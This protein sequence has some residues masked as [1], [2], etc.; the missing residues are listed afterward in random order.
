MTIRVEGNSLFAP[1]QLSTVLDLRMQQAK[2]AVSKVDPNELLSRPSDKIEYKIFEEYQMPIVY[3]DQSKMTAPQVEESSV[4][5][6]GEFSRGV[7]NDISTYVTA[8][9]ISLRIPYSGGS[10]LFWLT[11]STY[12]LNPPRGYVH[13]DSV[14]VS[15]LVPTDV[16][17]REQDRAITELRRMIDSIEEWINWVNRDIDEWTTQLRAVIDT[18]I[19][20]RRKILLEMRKI[21]TK[22]EVPIERDG[23]VARTYS[24]PVLKRRRPIQPTPRRTYEPFEPE[25]GISESNF[26]DIVTDITSV[27]TMFERLPITHFEAKEE[28]LR[29]QI[30]VTLNAI[31]GAGSA[32]TFSKR[33]KTDIY[34]P[35]KDNA[36][37]IAECK[38]WTG[39][40]AFSEE[41]LPQLLDQYVIWRDTHTAMILFI[42]NK[43][44][45]SVIEQAVKSVQQYPRYVEDTSPIGEM[46]TF[47]LHKEGDEDR[48]L[49]L[50]LITASI[51]SD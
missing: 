46:Q 22:L 48:R 39:Q 45:S 25:P 51:H 5:V 17:S 16:L 28:R 6:R 49:K 29:D 13:E 9:R 23:A 42:K 7:S 37:F 32:E 2:E 12:N 4:D 3:M 14:V 34:L 15:C 26:I 30:L 21:E 27:V 50:A 33:G 31:Y 40:K 35:W 1:N 19:K 8:A 43:G 11:P 18:A 10:S 24:V 47:A 38:W 41:A 20:D 44:V 36:V